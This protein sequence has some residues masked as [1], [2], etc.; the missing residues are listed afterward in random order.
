M[1][2]N[3]QCCHPTQ[4]RWPHPHTCIHFLKR[5]NPDTLCQYHAVA[6]CV[7]IRPML[8]MPL[9]YRPSPWARVDLRCLLPGSTA[10]HA[11]AHVLVSVPSRALQAEWSAAH[12][13]PGPWIIP[14]APMGSTVRLSSTC[15]PTRR[16]VRPL[17]TAVSPARTRDWVT[18]VF[19]LPSPEHGVP[20]RNSCFC[21]RHVLL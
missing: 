17:P 2:S 19:S 8:A 10:P 21:G 9:Q 3:K 11:A 1:L 7:A 20:G 6:T 14:D 4:P 13:H 18:A 16:G 5:Q 15:A 12:L